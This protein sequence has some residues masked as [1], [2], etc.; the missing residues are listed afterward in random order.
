M[1]DLMRSL[2]VDDW[3]WYIAALLPVVLGMLNGF[4]DDTLVEQI[5]VALLTIEESRVLLCWTRVARPC[6][7]QA[8]EAKLYDYTLNRKARLHF[9]LLV[10]SSSRE[11]DPIS[12]YSVVR[13]AREVP[14]LARHGQKRERDETRDSG[15]L[16]FYST[17]V[18]VFSS[19]RHTLGTYVGS[20]PTCPGMNGK[21]TGSERWSFAS[22][23]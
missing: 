7:D 21:V 18:Q 10:S 1:L 20:I 22:L 19:R 2:P 5:T 11:F 14:C 17:R 15:L 6:L 4:T 9:S 3:E 8:Q 23:D 16:L 12:Y 13:L